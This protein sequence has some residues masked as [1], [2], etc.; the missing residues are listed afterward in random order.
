MDFTLGRIGVLKKKIVTY[1]CNEDSPRCSGQTNL[2]F[3]ALVLLVIA[4]EKL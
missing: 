2:N 3:I 4:V 1:T